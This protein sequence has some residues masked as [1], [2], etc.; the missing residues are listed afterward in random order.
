MLLQV[1]R[2]KFVDVI[3]DWWTKVTVVSMLKPS[4]PS[5]VFQYLTSGNRLLAQAVYRK[6]EKAFYQ[7][8]ESILQSEEEN[9]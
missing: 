9:K 2:D 7:V 5:A 8:E 6:G 4:D 3:Q 1:E